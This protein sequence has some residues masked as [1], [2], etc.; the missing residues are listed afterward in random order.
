MV[1]AS[2]TPRRVERVSESWACSSFFIYIIV[3]VIFI[4][5]KLVC[6]CAKGHYSLISLFDMLY[7]GK[8]TLLRTLMS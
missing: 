7:I 8:G 2:L 4:I 5:L 3:V 6:V 1:L